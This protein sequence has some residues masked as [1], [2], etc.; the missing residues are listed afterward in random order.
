MKDQ[1]RN[2]VLEKIKDFLKNF[3][4]NFKKK[5][6]EA[7]FF[8]IESANRISSIFYEGVFPG[9]ETCFFINSIRIVA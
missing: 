5:N 3:E 4:K 2:L 9:L 6:I 8:E 7:F 1:A